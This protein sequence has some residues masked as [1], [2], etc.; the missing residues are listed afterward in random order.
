MQEK[1]LTAENI[2]TAP[3]KVST[4]RGAGQPENAG[5]NLTAKTAKPVAGVKLHE[6]R[7]RSAG[8]RRKKFNC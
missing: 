6:K 4:K 7:S 8:E 2:K 1:N 3:L 5:K